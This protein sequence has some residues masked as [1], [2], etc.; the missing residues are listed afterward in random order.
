MKI[1][2]FALSALSLQVSAASY[3]C[4]IP[5]QG[6]FYT[7]LTIK[8]NSEAVN[9]AVFRYSEFNEEGGFNNVEVVIAENF[10]IEDPSNEDFR[11]PVDTSEVEHSDMEDVNEIVVKSGFGYWG[12]TDCE[13][14]LNLSVVRA[15]KEEHV[16]GSGCLKV[17]EGQT[18]LDA[19]LACEDETL[20]RY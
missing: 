11:L 6:H 13:P 4:V 5:G 12:E 15:G 3:H 1:I 18:I 8:S 2:L 7:D 17:E 10:E 19:V 16:S 9:E 20:E 14:K